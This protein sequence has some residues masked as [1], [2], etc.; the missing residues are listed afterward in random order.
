MGRVSQADPHTHS[1][2]CHFMIPPGS[3]A[4]TCTDADSPDHPRCL[5]STEPR[6]RALRSPLSCSS[7]SHAAWVDPASLSNYGDPSQIS[8]NVSPQIKQLILN[9]FMA[10]GAGDETCFG[11]AIA[12]AVKFIDISVTACEAKKGRMEA[13]TVAE[14]VVAENMLNGARMLHG[15]CIAFLIDK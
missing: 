7:S 12:Q 11:H 15:G 9:T 8:G 2:S 1:L 10:Y 3:P 14:V 5:E 4:T 6:P 13:T